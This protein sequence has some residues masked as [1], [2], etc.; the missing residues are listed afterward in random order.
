[1]FDNRRQAVIFVFVLLIIVLGLTMAL[2]DKNSTQL[3]SVYGWSL[4][5]FGN[6]I[7]YFDFEYFQ[8]EY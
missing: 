5:F 4:V 6:V 1:M 8:G 7:A 3:T 2:G